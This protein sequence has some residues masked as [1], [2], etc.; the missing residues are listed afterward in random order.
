MKYENSSMSLW[1][2]N[3]S[4]CIKDAKAILKMQFE[5][6]SVAVKYT[7]VIISVY[8]IGLAALWLHFVRQKYGQVST[9]IL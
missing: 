2:G 5:A 7:T 1:C 9:G 4:Q 8:M 3:S 6:P